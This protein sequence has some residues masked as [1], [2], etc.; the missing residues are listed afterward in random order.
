MYV[1]RKM[2]PVRTIPGKRGGR[3][4]ENERGGEVNYNIL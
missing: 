1:N 4:K 3:R 2:R